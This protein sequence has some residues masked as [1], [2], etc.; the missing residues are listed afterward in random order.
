[1]AGK[2]TQFGLGAVVWAQDKLS[3]PMKNMGKAMGLF[4]NQMGKTQDM[5]VTVGDTMGVLSGTIQKARG[6]LAGTMSLTKS[7][8]DLEQR[9]LE[10]SK[11]TGLEG[12]AL[13]GVSSDMLDLSKKLPVTADGL[14][15]I[16][17]AAGQM[18]I[19]ARKDV[20][21]FTRITAQMAA[22][23]VF[24]AEEAGLSL[25]RIR[26]V[27]KLTIPEVE[28]MGSAMAG[29]ADSFAT[30][31]REIAEITQRLGPTARAAGI[32]VQETM[33][34]SAAMRDMGI[35]VE[36]A[37]TNMGLIIQRMTKDL[38]K[39]AAAIGEDAAAFE[40]LFREKPAEALNKFFGA[41]AGMDKIEVVKKMDELGLSGGRVSK[42]VLALAGNTEGLAKA[43][44]I[45]NDQFARGTRLQEEAE[46]QASGL[47]AQWTMFMN[48]V[49]ALGI[50]I[51]N[52]FLPFA[53]KVLAVLVTLVNIVNLVP[54]PILA[55]VV[56]FTALAAVLAIVVAS[57]A[58]LALK[59]QL[60]IPIFQKSVIWTLILW[61]SKKKLNRAQIQQMKTL[62]GI[63]KAM[64]FANLKAKA[65]AAWTV[66]LTAKTWLWNAALY[67]NPIGLIVAAVAAFIVGIILF[68]RW[69]DKAEGVT[70]ALGLALLFMM[71][72]IGSIAAAIVFL[73]HLWKKNFFWIQD[74][75]EEFGRRVDSIVK[76][77]KEAW[78]ELSAAVGE[79]FNAVET[80]F[81]NMVG[82][83]EEFAK[84]VN[85]VIEF[86]LKPVRILGKIFEKVFK[87]IAA[88]I[89]WVSGIFATMTE[90]NFEEKIN[91]L[92]DFIED[93]PEKIVG[94]FESLPKM[95]SGEMGDS[96]EEG[97]S[98]FF[99]TLKK[100]LP[101]LFK[102]IPKIFIALIKAL[103]KT[104]LLL[105]AVLGDA[106][107]SALASLGEKILDAGK[108]LISNLWEGIQ[109]K[110]K[111][112]K[113]KFTDLLTDI[114][115]LLPF[116]DAKEG[117]LSNITDSGTGLVNAMVSG[118]KQA[119]GIP[120]AVFSTIFG[121]VSDVFIDGVNT[122]VG[123]VN[124]LIT[125]A[126]KFIP[127]KGIPLIP[128]VEKGSVGGGGGGGAAAAARRPGPANRESVAGGLGNITVV[129][130]IM[131]D[132]TEIA[133]HV[134]ELTEEDFIRGFNRPLASARGV[135]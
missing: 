129:V 108:E 131:L 3:G 65:S 17:I 39:F 14:A 70:K 15:D 5:T 32:T 93:L 115:D 72:P 105:G 38:P 35:G 1:M 112:V 96:A 86:V 73:R 98:A 48:R 55:V 10:V 31:E 76:P 9:M 132:G 13:R 33:A 67:A 46:K 27:F 106:L 117:P 61:K 11:T 37:G 119:A 126:N 125:T 60:M 25:G 68:A 107:L 87:G 84:V 100:I 40:E 62:R 63:W 66:I 101:K 88:G 53:K 36:V 21:E 52:V 90:E 23:S 24:S 99:K 49:K 75:V 59:I 80:A 123:T 28:Q 134:I 42:V 124:S 20:A 111:E 95:I 94:F 19:S 133:R 74:I 41:F 79:L 91:E 64:S 110:W 78:N 116:S 85:E 121:A 81:I 104:L 54:K 34:L 2:S 103:G 47:N 26:S 8:A 4:N 16:A 97:G 83:P 92:V 69:V 114:R 51:G 6:V 22:A 118:M 113:K 89:K 130:P 102:A 29:L 58:L 135:L 120:K 43:Y 109:E 45:S 128:K 56:G 18:G 44:R 82:S 127:G 50:E 30:N 57:S 122:V 77:V 12:A 71:G 7:S